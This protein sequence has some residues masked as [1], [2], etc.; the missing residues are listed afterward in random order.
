MSRIGKQPIPV[1]SGVN[2][3]IDGQ[4][5]TVKG[6]KGELEMDVLEDIEVVM[7]DRI[8]SVKNRVE[9]RK[10]NAFR[11]LTRSLISN[12]V[13]GVDEGFKKNLIIEGV[14]Y[15]ASVSGSELTLNV[16]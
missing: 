15:K 12:M 5:V 9:S 11:G 6:S 16:G 13:V 10:V 14:G 4:S 8:I 3:K 2:V 7:E 1:P